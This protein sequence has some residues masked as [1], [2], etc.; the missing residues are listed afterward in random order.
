MLRPL[1]FQWEVSERIRQ[2][3]AEVQMTYSICAGNALML[4]TGYAEGN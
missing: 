3:Y 1:L 4:P 2:Q